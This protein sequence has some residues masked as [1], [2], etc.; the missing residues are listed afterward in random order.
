ME[1]KMIAVQT[2]VIEALSSKRALDVVSMDVSSVTP[3]ADSFVVASGNSDVHMRALVNAVTDC[4]DQHRCDYK[5]E[6]ESSAQWTLIDTG[7]IIIHIFS[8]KAREFYKLE[9][10]WGDV[11][12]VRHES[13]D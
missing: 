10:I 6:G 9:R 1:E 3:I 2:A 12:I 8:V 4:L 7:D 5:I 13:H 11:Q